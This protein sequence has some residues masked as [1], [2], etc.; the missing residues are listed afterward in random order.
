M[1]R[2]ASVLS[3][4]PRPATADTSEGTGRKGG[5][6]ASPLGRTPAASPPLGGTPAP[7]LPSA[8]TT[9]AASA[10]DGADALRRAVGAWRGSAYALGFGAAVS[11]STN[12]LHDLRTHAAL[13]VLMARAAGT[14]LPEDRWTQRGLAALTG[15]S[16]A[17]VHAL[18]GQACARG[19]FLRQASHG[20]RR[21]ALLVPS[22]AMAATFAAL[23]DAALAAAG[24]L[25]GTDP[26]APGPRESLV[27]D[28]A[29]FACALVRPHR[30]GGRL[31]FRTSALA[32]LLDLLAAGE[33]GIDPR[34]LMRLALRR[35]I[36]DAEAVQEE[37]TT[38]AMA[39]LVALTPRLGLR[40][41][42]EGRHHLRA[43]ADLWEDWAAMARGGGAKPAGAVQAWA[44]E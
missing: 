10:E 5:S 14:S 6:A 8:G 28:Y 7:S 16:M 15:L 9:A 22:P 35:G 17:G 37:M 23:L 40:L 44:A 18:V 19:E 21:R 38:A 43:L 27:Q 25:D 12:W 36:A 41:S 11:F 34:A 13:A 24:P 39:G 2:P 30:P 4:R 26:A 1:P 33:D 29:R 31:W 20:D 32:M 3:F 42:A